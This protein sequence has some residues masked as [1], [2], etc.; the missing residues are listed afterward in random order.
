MGYPVKLISSL[1]L[2]FLFA[3]LAA[4]QTPSPTPKPEI[5]EKDLEKFTYYFD[6]TDRGLSGDG[7]KFLMDEF[8]QNQFVL[9]GEYHGSKR[10]SEF[11]RA[12]IGP[13]HDA[14]FRY[15]GLEIGPISVDILSE[16]SSD[17][18][19]TRDRLS[20]FNSKYLTNRGD[21]SFT[22]IPF[23][24]YVED[25][26]FLTEAAKRRWT[27]LGLDQEFSFSYVPLI[28]RMYSDLPAKKKASL[29]A[30]YEA[31]L[32]EIASIYRDDAARTRNA[33]IAIS[34][35]AAINSFLDAAAEKHVKNK[36]I[37]EALRVTTEI[38]K[39]NANTIRKYYLANDTR[40][41][42]MKKNL[43]QGFSR[44]GFKL[45]RDKM[46]LKMGAV[47]TGRGFSPLSLFEI[48]NTLSELADF[49]GNSSLHVYFGSRFYLENGTVV[50]SLA[51]TSDFTYRFKAFAQ[52]GRRDKWA[53]IDLR[54][55]REAIFYHRR[56]EVDEVVLDIWKNHDIVII[57]PIDSDPTPN[58]KG[59]TAK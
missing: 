26:D 25:A 5:N 39:N 59:S 37:A 21:R 17:P 1:I 13:F 8:R 7:A 58:Y 14:G 20:T 42:Y 4:A 6:V 12:A 22:P 32:A 40:V 44:S 54:P 36:A 19:N 52:M 38:Y 2:I 43:T 27:L 53:V 46:L 15:F 11:T 3:S 23:F 51:N 41:R 47:H 55:L 56:F 45:E 49:N 18:K 31:A 29:K 35:S 57:P 16:L 28:D 33:Y 50:D 10:I 30:K 24:S 34:E 9:L 48:G